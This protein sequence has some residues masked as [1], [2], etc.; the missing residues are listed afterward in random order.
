MLSFVYDD[1]RDVLRGDIVLCTPVL[2]REAQQQGKTLAA[3]CAH[4]VV[5]G[6]L[7]LQGY[8]HV[9]DADAAADG[10]ARGRHPGAAGL[11]RSLRRRAAAPRQPDERRFQRPVR[12]ADAARAAVG[13]P[14]ART[15]RQG[16]AAQAAARRVRAQAARC[17]RAVD[18]RGRAS[19]LRDDG[20]RHHDPAGADGRRV[21]RRRTR[22]VH[23][24]G[25]GNAPLALPGD[26]REQGRRRRHPAG[27]GAAQLLRESGRLRAARHAASGRVRAGVQAAECAA[28]RLPRQP[29]PHGDR[30]RRIRRRVGPGHHRGRAR[31]DR[32]RHRGRV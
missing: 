2:R 17:R 31:A 32:R 4:L 20:S 15:G 30:R 6:T 11:P 14:V 8:D 27:E 5:H 10:G 13:F 26:R 28:A 23:T 9:A 7:H 22:A 24:V 16:G 29:Q 1:N 12:Q 25:A 18:H 3:H 19:G 21:D